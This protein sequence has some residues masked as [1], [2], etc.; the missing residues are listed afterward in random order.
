MRNWPLLAVVALVAAAAIADPVLAQVGGNDPIAGIIQPKATALN[1]S[2]NRVIG[3]LGG[4]AV[5]IAIGVG[6]FTRK[7]PWVW[8]ASIFGGMLVIG[9]YQIITSWLGIT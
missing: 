5:I 8:L 7:I 4:L 1:T 6:F 2:A 3:A 9:G